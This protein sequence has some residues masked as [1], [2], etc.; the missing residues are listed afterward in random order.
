MQEKRY[1]LIGEK[2]GHS[3]S[4]FIHNK[5]GLNYELKEIPRYN[6]KSFLD[7]GY[8]GF[9]VTIPYKKD[10]IKF[11]DGISE[12]A[13]KIGAV[14]T[15]VK[16]DGKLFGYNTDISG[17]EYALKR[18]GISLKDRRV[19]ILGSG[20]TFRTAKALAEKQGAKRVVFV[21]R[22][23]EINYEN[24]YNL[25]DTE[26]IINATP[27][28]M[29]PN[30]YDCPIKV[31][32]FD[33]LTAILD[34]VYN[35]FKTELIKRA[36]KLGVICTDGTPMLITQALF[37]E[38]I[39]GYKVKKDRVE[40]IISDLYAKKMNI[41]LIGMPSA[42][43]SSVGKMLAEKTGKKFID[44]DEEILK[45]T[46]LSPASI[47]SEKGE[48]AFR[49]IETA[50]VK[51]IASTNG[52]VIATGGGVPLKSENVSALKSNGVI[53]YIKRETS[54]LTANGRPISK[55]RGIDN[56]YKERKGFYESAAE[57]TVENN[58]KIIDCVNELSEKINKYDINPKI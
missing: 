53:A 47:I 46:G 2:L 31:E 12:D 29:F 56:L 57:I 58:G 34:C 15:V 28:G 35:P 40:E 8:D 30:I 27:V 25:K 51:K 11:L 17:M 14:N 44:T 54:L 5:Q 37:A 19:M 7:E 32:E 18:K 26:V 13:E 16:K 49:D 50:V 24:C 42:G 21:S 36:E 9:N 22:T 20:G 38:E 55:E 43:K 10:V 4:A 39:W 41:A 52:A 1:C 45:E 23:G 3:Y 33:N 48:K 6:L